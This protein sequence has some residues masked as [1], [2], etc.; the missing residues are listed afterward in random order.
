[1]KPLKSLVWYATSGLQLGSN[2]LSGVIETVRR[3]F[4][5]CN[6]VLVNGYPTKTTLNFLRIS[7]LPVIRGEKIDIEGWH[8]LFRD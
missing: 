1:M 8:I 5:S 6:L 3:F 7:K 2:L 4:A